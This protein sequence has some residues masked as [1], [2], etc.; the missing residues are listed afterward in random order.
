MS[1]FSAEEHVAVLLRTLMLDVQYQ[2]DDLRREM[3]LFTLFAWVTA[4]RKA[5]RESRRSSANLN[6]VLGQTEAALLA[7]FRGYESRL[8]AQIEGILLAAR[9]RF[10]ASM[11][12]IS[13]EV[14]FAKAKNI[15]VASL[16]FLAL[17]MHESFTNTLRFFVKTLVFRMRND[18]LLPESKALS[19]VM[20]PVFSDAEDLFDDLG[21]TWPESDRELRTATK[22]AEYLLPKTGPV[23]RLQSSLYQVAGD[24]AFT[25]LV[26][27]IW[28]VFEDS[29]SLRG[30]AAIVV[31]DANTTDFCRGLLGGQWDASTAKPLKESRVQLDFPGFPPYHEHCRTTMTPIFH[32]DL[33]FKSNITT[34]GQVPTFHGDDWLKIL[35]PAERNK[36]VAEGIRH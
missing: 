5:T 24:F 18:Q 31:N 27:Q 22:Q 19:S 29:S 3:A 23:S 2:V 35:P 15:K 32:K 6:R 30:W 33:V 28:P 13:G 36:Y 10:D 11:E 16:Q 9:E 1:K 4:V 20:G 12:D 26:D 25:G 7:K 34:S 14:R 8:E 21:G 17:N